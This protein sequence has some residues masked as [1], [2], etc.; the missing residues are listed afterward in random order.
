MKIIHFGDLHVW[1]LP[2]APY[3]PFFIKRYMG[4]FNLIFHRRKKFPPA[5]GQKVL[6]SILEQDA[7]LVIFSGDL[8]TSAQKNEFLAAKELLKPIEE[9]WG[10]KFFMIPGNHDRYTT[11]SCKEDWYGQYFP[12]GKIE[13]V[14]S[15]VIDEQTVVI[16]YD[17]S[18]E[19]LFRSNGYFHEE[20]AQQLKAEIQRHDGK[21]V[22][23]VGHYPVEYPPE[24]TINSNHEMLNR[25]LLQELMAEHPPVL[26]LH[27]HKHIRWHLGNA[28]NCGA[29]G[30]QSDQPNCQ[31]GYCIIELDDKEKSITSVEMIDIHLN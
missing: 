1:K 22:I 18:K 10:E 4:A 11:K 24:V 6:D 16:G 27:G 21:K 28:V 9:K 23:L 7:D 17:A 5:L 26:Y 31:A 30:M 15:L 12:N 3:D 19:F 25:N 13:G 29:A 14:R 20:L 2:F 8:T